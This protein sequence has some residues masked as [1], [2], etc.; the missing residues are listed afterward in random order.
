MMKKSF[1]IPQWRVSSK[2]HY[3][4]LASIALICM[5]LFVLLLSSNV[6]AQPQQQDSTELKIGYIGLANSNMARGV[7]LAIQEINDAGG[8]DDPNGVT[9]TF[10][11]EV[12]EVSEDNPSEVGNAVQQLTN[13]QVVAI[14][15]PDTTAL[16]QPNIVAL[17]NA[18][19]PVL[20]GATS[21][22]LLDEDVN[23]NIFRLVAPD[24]VYDT[25]LADFLVGELNVQRIVV[26]Q[27]SNDWTNA[28]L[29]FNT[30]LS[31]RGVAPLNSLLLPDNSELEVNIRVL[32]ELNPD[33][34][35][36]YG[37]PN[38][39]LTVLNQLKSSG[40]TG[41]FAYRSAR[42]GLN[43][44]NF[45]VNDLAEGVIGVGSWTSGA[46]DQVGSQFIVNYVGQFG[47][48]PGALSAAGYDG[49]YVLRRVINS[50]GPE[51]ASI[52]QLMSQ[53]GNL[54][55]VRGPVNP[56]VYG[57]RNLAR[58]ALVFELTGEGGARAVAAYDNGELRE[59]AGFG[60]EVAGVPT[61]TPT[62]TPTPIPSPTP[63]PSAT[64]SVVTAT[65]TARVLNVRSGPSTEFER[66]TQLQQGRQITVA[67]R[68]NDFS[69]L[70]VQF[71]GRVGWVTADLVDIF[72][73]GGL[74]AT[75][76]IVQPPPTPTPQPTQ[77]SPDAD[78]IITNVTLT[79]AQPQPGIPVTANVTILNQGSAAAG[80]FAVATSFKPGELYSA[81]NV[82]G[83]AA[84]QTT[85]VPLTTTFT[86]TGYVPDLAIIVD[87][88][89]QVFEGSAGSV[90]ESNNIYI[91][92]Y[93]VDRS[94]AAQAQTSLSSGG[95]VNFFGP[96]IDLNWDGSTFSTPV[97]AA[98]I[99][100]LSAGITF[101]TSH[102]DQVP[103][104]AT[105]TSAGNPPVGGVYA[106]ITD[107]GYY[108]VL[109]VDGRS[110]L[111][112]VFTYRVYT[113]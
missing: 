45:A 30:T 60:G 97:G 99:G 65:V 34:V 64:P 63:F 112:I 53:L 2:Q 41:V 109:R 89:S 8:V 58:T 44:P 86:Q 82:G 80:P 4:S 110:G 55:L 20:T 36:M 51:A 5:M 10:A 100:P 66:V 56:S 111:D 85:I 108:G 93:K 84:G 26:V 70:F 21:E 87:L 67:G 73:P 28:V 37:P 106:F 69:W 98:R 39:A 103:T 29:A 23:S 33:A 17:T 101:E 24:N 96:N 91:L 35:M 95:S 78:L 32:P 3:Q 46:N 76:P 19:V 25:A 54:S 16:A 68:N 52:R 1:N 105:S 61:S 77:Q 102:Y 92:T 90:G 12:I 59:A 74:L 6:F 49:M 7:Q 9:Y 113:P 22:T 107:E 14:F 42:Q 62:V 38:D 50:G 104:Y 15:G 88:N 47:A 57:N 71:D 81:Q 75:I 43:D 83:L 31:T 79:P 18:S 27:T 48:I 13:Q 11:L 94:V 72:D 40:W